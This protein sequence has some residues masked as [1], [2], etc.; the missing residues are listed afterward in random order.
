MSKNAFINAVAHFD[1]TFDMHTC[2]AWLSMAAHTADS[3]PHVCCSSFNL[4]LR[5]RGIALRA[6]DVA[7]SSCQQLLGGCGGACRQP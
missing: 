5:T 4:I 3:S 7:F 1:Y 6:A 2:K